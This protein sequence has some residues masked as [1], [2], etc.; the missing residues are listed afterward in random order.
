MSLK[1]LSWLW[2]SG[3]AGSAEEENEMPQMVTARSNRVRRAIGHRQVSQQEPAEHVIWVYAITDRLV[4]EQLNGL[5]GVGGERVRAVS[6]AG[7]TAVVGS[8]DAEAF[9]EQAR[10]TLLSDLASIERLGRTHHQVIACVAAENPVLPLRLATVYPSDQTVLARLRQSSAEF[11]VML[12]S[13]RGTEE[14]GVK[15]YAGAAQEAQGG[16]AA[17]GEAVTAEEDLLTSPADGLASPADGLAGPADELASPGDELSV[18]ED[19]SA[20]PVP[21][22]DAEACAEMIDRALSGIAVATRRQAAAEPSLDG[23]EN[24]LVLNAAYLLNSDRAT[25]FAA[26]ARAL[27]GTHSGMRADLTGPWPPYSFADLH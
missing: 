18:P 14:W 4:P 16:Q 1:K 25:E 26:I 10:T 21:G 9:G 23:P 7:L 15:V 2:E 17:P 3:V 27:A 11:A 22:R 12:E 24:W 5:T 19:R 8:V 20:K 6:E 13:F